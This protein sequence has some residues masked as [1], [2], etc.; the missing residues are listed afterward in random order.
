MRCHGSRYSIISY[1]KTFCYPQDQHHCV[2]LTI[3]YILSF[4]LLWK[5]VTKMFRRQKPALRRSCSRCSPEG[6][7]TNIFTF[8]ANL[9]VFPSTSFP[10][11]N[12]PNIFTFCGIYFLNLLFCLPPLLLLMMMAFQTLSDTIFLFVAILS[13]FL[14]MKIFVSNSER[15]SVLPP[16]LFLASK[17]SEVKTDWS[18]VQEPMSLQ[19]WTSQSVMVQKNRV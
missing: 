6:G 14:F 8:A 19:P 13:F 5:K 18:D 10:V 3:K 17:I 7:F 9:L 11:D 12:F 1:K 15:A 4:I 16:C 2:R